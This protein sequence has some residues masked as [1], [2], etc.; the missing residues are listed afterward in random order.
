MKTTIINGCTIYY[1]VNDGKVHIEKTK[2]DNEIGQ[3]LTLDAIEGLPVT[4][5]GDSFLYYNEI[6]T[7][8]NLPNV[9]SIGNCF[10]Y[11][12]ETL[13]EVNLPNVTSIG[14][15]FLCY[16]ETLTEVNLPNVTSI[17]NGFLCC[18]KNVV[19]SNG[20]IINN[21]GIPVFVKSKKT[22]Q[23]FTI[24]KGNA[25][26]IEGKETFV[27]VKDKYSAHGKTIEKAIEDCNFKFL[28]ETINVEEYVKEVK[29]KGVMTIQDYRLLTGAC[30]QGCL[31]FLENNGLKG[32]TELP[33]EK[34]LTL[35][36]GAYN[37]DKVKHLF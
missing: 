11:Y 17:G 14:Y 29:A 12:N 23:D 2:N 19:I 18:N 30:E 21:D 4:S 9:T 13:T 1:T 7:E 6:L 20:T 15:D 16:N 5:I 26:K 36:S 33:L 35:V 34:A 37:F 32:K 25:Y 27:A 31:M 28:Q 3:T 22:V 10:L 8:V 24:Y